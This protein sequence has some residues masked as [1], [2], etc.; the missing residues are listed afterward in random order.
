[1]ASSKD[2]PKDAPDGKK[3]EKGKGKKDEKMEDVLSDEDLVR[4]PW[5]PTGPGDRGRA[6]RWGDCSSFGPPVLHPSPLLPPHPA[7]RGIEAARLHLP[8]VEGR[9]AAQTGRPAGG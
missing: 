2:A 5:T 8:S 7:A 6:G 9:V 1:M 4:A 3:A